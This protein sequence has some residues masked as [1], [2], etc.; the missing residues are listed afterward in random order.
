MKYLFAFLTILVLA[1]MACS[2]TVNL[3]PVPTPGPEVTDE[4]TV[5]VPEPALSA[6]EV[7][8]E[9]RLKISFGAGELRLFPGAG[10]MLV[11]GTALYDIP[12]FKPEIEET[13]GLVEI[14]Q[15]EIKTLNVTDFKNE[16]DLQIGETPL[17]LEINAGAYKGRYE[18]GGLALTNLT[19]KDGA[20]DVELSFSEPNLTEMSVFRYETGASSVELTGLANA[21]FSTLIFNGGAGEYTLDFSGDLGQDATARVETGFGDLK[22]V[23][24]KG[25]DARITVE[26]G[27]VNINHSS[28]WG[29]S[30]KTYTQEG[31]GPT[32]MIIVKVGAGNVT[33]TD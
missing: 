11:E 22:L 24:P 9:P 7:T 18:F 6:D 1:S 28:G 29:Q 10:D 16:W 30:N 12:N 26:G 21:N 2:F 3:P 25:V 17:E 5:A 14:K 31:S 20:S 8:D 23:V 19:I 27:P 32:L 13:D 4:I 15:G 33:I